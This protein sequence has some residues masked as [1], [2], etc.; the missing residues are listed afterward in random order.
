MDGGDT[1]PVFPY[2]FVNFVSIEEAGRARSFF[3]GIV[4]GANTLEVKWRGK[5][6]QKGPQ[7]LEECVA[8][9]HVD[10]LAMQESDDKYKPALYLK[11]E[12]IEWKPVAKP[13][14][15]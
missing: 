2:A 15:L 13:V 5:K 6:D 9:Y 3:D 10:S 8:R 12:R 11:G 4:C 7:N 14:E 1:R